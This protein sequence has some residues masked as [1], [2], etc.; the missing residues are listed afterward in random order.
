VRTH[1]DP[2]GDAVVEFESEEELRAAY[3]GDLAAGGVRVTTDVEIP[4]FSEIR[5]TLRLA[6]GG[7]ITALGT[8]VN[9]IGGDL[10]VAFDL[11]PDA[12]LAALEPA[13]VAEAPPVPDAVERDPGLWER[14]RGCSRNEKLLL[15][16]KASRAERVV[17][18]QENDAQILYYLLKN[19]RVTVDEV[20]RIARSHLLTSATAD[21]IAKTSTWSSSAEVRVAL[22]NNPRAPT[23]LALRLLPTLP[24]TEIRKIAKATAV[25]QAIKQAALRIV[26]GRG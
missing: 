26:V 18:L 5:L 25:S 2:T 8:V 19:P 3:A 15:A 14:I 23:P 17:L 24:E 16:P 13:P 1:V 12:V 6:G 21:L 4:L 22:V 20:V 9:R 11:A 10:A 7:E